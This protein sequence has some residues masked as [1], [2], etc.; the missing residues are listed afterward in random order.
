MTAPAA[1]QADAVLHI[2]QQ[3]YPQA[4]CSLHYSTPLQLLVATVLSAQCTDARVNQVT[5]ELFARYPEPQSYLQASEAQLQQDIRSTGFYRQKAATLRAIMQ[6]VINRFDGQ[7]PNRMADLVSIPGVGRKTANVLLG[8]ACDV[9]PEGIAVDTHVSRVSQRLGLSS[10]TT[11]AKIEI[12]LMALFARVVWP[13]LSHLLI[14]HG[15]AI[16]K[17]RTPLCQNCA[18][19][20]HCQYFATRASGQ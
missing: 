12:D 1:A 6:A 2:L 17:A 19:A 10:Q 16:C 11:P 9:E 7:V 13:Q 20:E 4:E 15:R 5:P 3:L 18:L 8:N 14:A